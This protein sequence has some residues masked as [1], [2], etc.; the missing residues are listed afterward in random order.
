MAD[1][2]ITF[3][4]RAPTHCYARQYR[5]RRKSNGPIDLII[6]LPQ[7]SSVLYEVTLC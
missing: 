3:G 5:Y 4:L 6:S 2:S 1:D 7:Y